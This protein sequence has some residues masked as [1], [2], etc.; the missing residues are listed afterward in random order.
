MRN[1]EYACAAFDVIDLY[2]GLR[3]AGSNE[4]EASSI[5]Q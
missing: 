3:V 1:E 5:A 2:I 4:A